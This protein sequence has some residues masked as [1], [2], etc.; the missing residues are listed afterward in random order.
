MQ[1]FSYLIIFKV[2]SR[3]TGT[4]Q[5]LWCFFY[6]VT[7]NSEFRPKI[8]VNSVIRS[9]QKFRTYF[10]YP[11]L[12]SQKRAKKTA[13][14]SIKS[15]DL[16]FSCSAFYPKSIKINFK[17]NLFIIT[18]VLSGPAIYDILCL[19][20]PPSRTTGWVGVWV[21]LVEVVGLCVSHFCI[22]K[23][24]ETLQSQCF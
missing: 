22:G 21:A 16:K 11:A 15:G 24:L 5:N 14:F 4:L 8:F 13:R 10:S 19:F 18:I 23:H 7:E 20:H 9:L 2:S 12:F 3:I 17:E 6:K 1:T